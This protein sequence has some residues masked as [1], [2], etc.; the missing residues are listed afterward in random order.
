MARC[1]REIDVDLQDLRE[2]APGLFNRRESIPVVSE[3]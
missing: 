3:T 1:L 2:E